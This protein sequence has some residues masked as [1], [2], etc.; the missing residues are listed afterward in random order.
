MNYTETKRKSAFFSFWFSYTERNS[1]IK[2]PKTGKSVQALF[3]IGIIE[4]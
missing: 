3:R 2:F 4:N 1:G